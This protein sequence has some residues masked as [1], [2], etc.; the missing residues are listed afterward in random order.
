MSD[1]QVNLVPQVEKAPEQSVDLGLEKEKGIEGVEESKEVQEMKKES[2]T[3]VV[4][5]EEK[6]QD[7]P[8]VSV[9]KAAPAQPTQVPI[10]KDELLT[11]IE[12]ILADDLT[13]IFL[14][15]PD[16]KKL[17]FK[18]KGEEV[19][20]KIR[21]MIQSG[22]IKIGKILDWIREWLSMIPRVN[23]YFIDQEAKIKADKVLKYTE[24]QKKRLLK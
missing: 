1:A 18:Q 9:L 4:R 19:A 10:K 14:E 3:E 8:E 21:E 12:T 20:G 24:D 2:D 7:A 23:K 13:E 17:A 6:P 15:L 16:E 11:D 5:E 22:K